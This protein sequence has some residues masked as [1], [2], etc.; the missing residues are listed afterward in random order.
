MSVTVTALHLRQW[1]S[2]R[3]A[4]E[5]LSD[6]LGEGAV[7]WQQR[8][9]VVYGRR[10]PQPRLTASFGRQYRYSGLNHPETPVPPG[11]EGLIARVGEVAGVQFNS[12]LLNRYRD[13]RDSIGRHRDDEA[14]LGVDPIVASLSLG[15]ARRFLLHPEGGGSQVVHQ[16]QHGDL[17]VMPAGFQSQWQHSMPKAGGLVGERVS[18]TFRR[19]VESAV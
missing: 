4:G 18:I 15:A 9:I 6:L 3:D 19:I 2:R 17:F 5:L 8:Q 16:L 10:Y 11:L 7:G 13:G 14:G 12:L 1:M